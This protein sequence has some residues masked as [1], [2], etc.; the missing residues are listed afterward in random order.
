VYIVQHPYG[1][2]K[3]F[4]LTSN[5]VTFLNDRT[6]QYLTTTVPGSSGAPVFDERWE[7]I[8]LHHAAA[9]V[10]TDGSVF[11]NEGIRIDRIVKGLRDKGLLDG[12]AKK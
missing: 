1:G 7:V 5:K 8:A 9:T 2:P 3:K 11:R 10:G 12:S 6:I 4:N